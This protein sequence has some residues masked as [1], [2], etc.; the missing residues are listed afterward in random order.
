MLAFQHAKLH[1]FDLADEYQRKTTLSSGN[2][3]N[4]TAYHPDAVAREL[5][6]YKVCLNEGGYG[7]RVLLTRGLWH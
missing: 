1:L 2:D 5:K 7:K 6:D 3:N 4:I